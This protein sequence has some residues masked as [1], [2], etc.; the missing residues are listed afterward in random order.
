MRNFADTFDLLLPGIGVFLLLLAV[1]AAWFA[2]PAMIVVLLYFDLTPW[3]QI[4]ALLFVLLLAFKTWRVH[5]TSGLAVLC[6]PLLAYALAAFPYPGTSPV[7]WAVHSAQAIYLRS[8]LQQEYLRAAA[9]GQAR[10]VGYLYLDGFGSYT[11]GLAYDPSG[12]I[13]LPSDRRSKPWND[14]AGQTEMGIESLEA[15]HLF[16][17]YYQ[18]FHE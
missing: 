2:L 5:W 11:S 9:G 18:W 14:G 16:G 10:P 8:E 3:L 13:A 7:S 12:E 4:S 6:A 1:A 17:P 15:H